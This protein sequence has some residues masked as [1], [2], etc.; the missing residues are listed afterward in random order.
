MAKPGGIIMN[1]IRKPINPAAAAM[2]IL[3][4]PYPTA[5]MQ[6][7]TLRARTALRPRVDW[8]LRDKA[9]VLNNRPGSLDT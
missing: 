7:R 4:R 5:A 6:A 2:G 8:H 1:A 3:E 9:W